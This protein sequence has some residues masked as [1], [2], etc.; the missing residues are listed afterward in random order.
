MGGDD[1]LLPGL[2]GDSARV[3]S[4]WTALRKDRR[5]APEVA[6]DLRD[7][8]VTP[9]D[10][11]HTTPREQ[12]AERSGESLGDV[13]L[14]TVEEHAEN[15]G[16]RHSHDMAV[17]EVHPEQVRVCEALVLVEGFEPPLNRF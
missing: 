4:A 2:E 17:A 6:C 1:P 13:P 10:P 15:V 11:S 14:L 8:G 3:L 12:H 16:A 5:P 7:G 9:F